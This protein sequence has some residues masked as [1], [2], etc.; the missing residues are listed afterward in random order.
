MRFKYL[1]GGVL[2][3]IYRALRIFPNSDPIMGFILPAA[4]NEP[5]WK[6]PLFAFTTMFAF[7]IF[8]S[9]IGTWTY[10]TS[11][12]YALIALAFTFY[13]RNKKASIA[14]YMKAGAA[15]VL[16]FDFITGPVMSSALFGQ[17][18]A[19]TLLM[20]I[21]FTIMHFVSAAFAIVL[22]TPFLDVQIMK[23]MAGY[24]NAAKYALLSRRIQT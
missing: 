5:L 19:L 9:G 20:Q 18:F 10:V 16:V 6:A 13:F 4:K 17:S 22:I 1:I 21:P 23:E 15:G 7:D 11:T 24:I 12:M 8:T 14:G 2:T 3:E